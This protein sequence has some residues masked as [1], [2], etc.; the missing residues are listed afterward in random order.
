MNENIQHMFVIAN[1]Y[2]IKYERK[3]GFEHSIIGK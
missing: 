3:Q 1:G 2:A